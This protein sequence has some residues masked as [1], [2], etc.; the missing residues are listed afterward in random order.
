MNLDKKDINDSS[1]DVLIQ[2]IKNIET[3]LASI[4]EAN[5]KFSTLNTIN[6]LNSLSVKPN[7]VILSS[8][9]EI[10]NLIE[11][12]V[13]LASGNKEA[14]RIPLIY[15]IYHSN[16]C[17]KSMCNNEINPR[18]ISKQ[19]TSWLLNLEDEVYKNIKHKDLN[20][21][22]L[23][24]KLAV[25]ERQLHRKIKSLLHLTPNKYIRVLRLHKAKQCIDDYLYDTISQISYAVGYYDTHYFSKLFKQ[26]YSVSP[27]ELLNS[28]RL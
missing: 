8:S 23:S 14:E 5:K 1:S 12:V 17:V 22:D 13:K 26:Q 24:Y 28:R 2:L 3:P 27:K 19:D 11:E 15:K 16:E 7:E 21:Y 6:A 9:Q 25:S 20:L 18:K 10:A 4:I